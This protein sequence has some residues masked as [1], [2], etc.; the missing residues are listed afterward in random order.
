MVAYFCT[1]IFFHYGIAV[2][3]TSFCNGH[4]ATEILFSSLEYQKTL[5]QQIIGS[6][7]TVAM[8]HTQICHSPQHGRKQRSS[9]NHNIHFPETAKQGPISMHANQPLYSWK[10]VFTYYVGDSLFATHALLLSFC[11]FEKPI[12]Y[13]ITLVVP[14]LAQYLLM[15]QR[16]NM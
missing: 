15:S 8:R 13:Y 14:S 5:V 4:S 3:S 16:A 2:D 1:S 11:L 12:D 6:K 7:M 10:E 9:L